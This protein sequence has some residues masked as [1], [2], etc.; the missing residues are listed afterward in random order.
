M[1]TTLN[2]AL[3]TPGIETSR[4]RLDIFLVADCSGSMHGPKIAALNHGMR[5]SIAELKNEAGQ[6]P[7]VDYRIRCIAFDDKANWHMGPN[8]LELDKA[9]WS[10]LSVGGCTSTG[11]AVQMLADAVRISDMPRRGFPPVMALVS[12]G[13]NTDGSAYDRAIEALEKERWGSKA[14]RLSIGIGDRYDRKQLE[15]FTNHPEVGVLEAKNAV[16]LVNYIKY[17]TVTASK[18]ASRNSTTPGQLNNNVALPAPPP[19]VTNNE[20]LNLQ[21]F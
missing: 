10:D 11:A 4:R 19:P 6:H 17:V 12:D 5:E 1:N 14:I 20:N 8:P 7:E 15:K 9:S 21:V 13:A 2:D 16:D 3:V 18:A